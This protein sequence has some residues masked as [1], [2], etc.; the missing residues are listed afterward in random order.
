MSE[1]GKGDR[2]RRNYDRIDWSDDGPE[3]PDT[4]HRDRF[5]PASIYLPG[6]P[7]PY[8]GLGWAR[9]GIVPG[10]SV[11]D[12][13]Q[14]EAVAHVH[15]PF[16]TARQI[17]DPIMEAT[18]VELLCPLYLPDGGVVHERWRAFL[19]DAS[20]LEVG[21]W[22]ELRFQLRSSEALEDTLERFRGRMA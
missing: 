4:P 11:L 9:L 14:V 13:L 3:G 16:E 10:P 18:E 17:R 15:V 19:S 8:T 5:G 20:D 2:Y 1:A 12:S 6:D 7:S 21:G 22:W